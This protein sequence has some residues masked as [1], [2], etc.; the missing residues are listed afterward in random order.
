MEIVIASDQERPTVFAEIQK[1]GGTY[2]DV[3]YSAEQ[4]GYVLT[5]YGAPDD[6][7]SVDLAEFR[8]ALDEAK[9]ALVERGFPDLPT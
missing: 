2:A 5:L 6:Y 8:K 4:D 7:L 9:A 1:D 3:I